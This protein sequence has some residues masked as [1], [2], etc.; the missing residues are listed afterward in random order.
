[1]SFKVHWVISGPDHVVWVH[2]P[3]GRADEN[4]WYTD[5]TGWTAAHEFG[6]MLGVL[7][8]YD[9]PEKCPGREPINTGTIMAM[10]WSTLVPERLVQ[11]VAN[12]I[13]SN[14]E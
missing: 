12:E 3:S 11:F 13:R 7:D 4:D 1:V 10:T 2:P 14:L 8:E 5:D 9:E 6:H